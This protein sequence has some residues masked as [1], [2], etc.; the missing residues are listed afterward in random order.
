[1][2]TERD[3]LAGFKYWCDRVYALET[4]LT[5]V[6]MKADQVDIDQ[7]LRELQRARVA[8]Q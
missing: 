5:A 1:M 4:C 8:K 6:T 7:H 2:T 3:A